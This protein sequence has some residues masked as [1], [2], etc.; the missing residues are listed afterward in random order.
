M[1]A[2]SSSPAGADTRPLGVRRNCA[3]RQRSGSS[4]SPT[5]PSIRALIRPASSR[6]R[7]RGIG[8]MPPTTRS[9]Q[10]ASAQGTAPR[11]RQYN[12]GSSSG[13]PIRAWQTVVSRFWSS[14]PG[15]RRSST[16]RSPW[17]CRTMLGR[18]SLPRTTRSTGPSSTA[19]PRASGSGQEWATAA[20][21]A[22]RDPRLPA[23]RNTTWS[24]R[25]VCRGS[26]V[27]EWDSMAAVTSPPWPAR[28]RPRCR[29]DRTWRAPR[30]AVPEPVGAGC[31]AGRFPGG[32]G[33]PW[34]RRSAGCSAAHCRRA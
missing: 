19:S 13:G 26:P 3:T 14:K 7:S 10:P 9:T 6:S 23:H 27:G 21:P 28:P 32:R 16:T 4:T 34:P 30:P 2:L 31:R 11:L 12:G 1:N 5:F 33:C 17:R 24:I 22:P 8:S 18:C 15:V 25:G 20:I 29:A